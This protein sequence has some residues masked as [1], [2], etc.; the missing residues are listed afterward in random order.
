MVFGTRAR[1][2]F[3]EL[4]SE[5]NEALLHR[6]TELYE[7]LQGNPSKTIRTKLDFLEQVIARLEKER[8]EAV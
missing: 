5:I 3:P 7:H 6:A 2:L 8:S 1:E 4:F